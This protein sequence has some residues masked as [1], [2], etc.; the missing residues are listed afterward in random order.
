MWGE[1]ERRQTDREIHGGTGAQ[2]SSQGCFLHWPQFLNAVQKEQFLFLHQALITI[3]CVCSIALAVV[4]SGTGMDP[5]PHSVRFM[6]Q[7]RGGQQRRIH[8]HAKCNSEPGALNRMRGLR[9]GDGRTAPRWAQR[10]HDARIG[11]T[12]GRKTLE[13]GTEH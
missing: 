4:C 8:T 13:C 3:S 2:P 10:Y 6:A 7:Q 1:K 5:G 12:S 11:G 9:K